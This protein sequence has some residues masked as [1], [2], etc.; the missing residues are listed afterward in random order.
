MQFKLSRFLA[1]RMDRRLLFV[2]LCFSVTTF[3]VYETFFD[4]L[5]PFVPGGS[6]RS[7]SGPFFLVPVLLLLSAQTLFITWLTHV[8]IATVAPSEKDALR[9]YC[10]ASGQILLF[11]IFYV[12]FPY[13][14]PYTF[15]VYFMPNQG[16]A[17]YTYPILVVWTVT[18][19]LVTF[20]LIR[21]AFRLE[22]NSNFGSGRRLLLAATM[23]AITMVI[24]S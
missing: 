21:R 16:F 23:L 15:V 14:G 18:T 13:Y 8:V 11:S 9:A 22:S 6:V 1:Y 3:A 20:L 19:I 5:V 2:S 4:I 10:V 12:F 7:N 17:P 24:A